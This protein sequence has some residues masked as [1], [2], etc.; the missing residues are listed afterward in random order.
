MAGL[1]RPA[2]VADAA[3]IARLQVVSWRVTYRDFVSAEFLSGFSVEAKTLS[4]EG[5]ITERQIPTMVWE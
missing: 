4:W 3:S 5:A 2:K 1:I